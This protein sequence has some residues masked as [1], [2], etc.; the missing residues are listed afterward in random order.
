METV[1]VAGGAGFIGSHLCE[2]LLG[3]SYSVIC[4]DNLITSD[5]KNIEPLFKNPNFQ[6]IESDICSLSA[7]DIPQ[8]QYIFHMASPASPNAKSARSYIAYPLETLLANSQG[9]HALLEI[10]KQTGARMLF[11]STSEVYGDPTVS[12]QPETYWGNVNPNGVRSVY[13]EAKRF[14]EAIM[15]AYVRKYNVDGRIVRIFNTYGPNMQ[16]DDGRVVSNLINQALK[17]EPLSVYGD[18]NQTRSFCYVSDLVEGLI[19]FMFG[20]NLQGEVIN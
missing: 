17:N 20:D 14:G 9:T 7:K 4:I 11:A 6:F 15:M 8:P 3:S 5:R 16:V 18:G 10:A 13:D 12:P 2:Q 1:W 19:A